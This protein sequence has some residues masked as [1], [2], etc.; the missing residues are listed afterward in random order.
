[1]SFLEG[2]ID[3]YATSSGMLTGTSMIPPLWSMHENVALY[4]ESSFA[5]ILTCSSSVFFGTTSCEA[6]L[7]A[8]KL[9][10]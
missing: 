7:R 10:S 2:N 3:S 1:M 4:N 8:Q 6:S 9:M 5:G